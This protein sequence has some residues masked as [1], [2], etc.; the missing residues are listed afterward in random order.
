MAGYECK[1]TLHVT[2]CQVEYRLKSSIWWLYNGIYGQL[3]HLS[4]VF[5][6]ARI[7]ASIE[8]CG[9]KKSRYRAR[10][11][12]FWYLDFFGENGVKI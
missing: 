9:S 4:Q 3:V 8:N 12:T 7:N 6:E 5:M 11:S 2:V 1:K 10:L